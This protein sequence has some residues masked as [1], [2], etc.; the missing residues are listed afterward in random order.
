M[1]CVKLCARC[2]VAKPHADFYKDKTVSDG[3]RRY[4][5][6][7]WQGIQNAWRAANPE[8]VK[9]SAARHDRKRRVTDPLHFVKKIVNERRRQALLRGIPFEISLDTVPPVP[10]LC[11]ALGIPLISGGQDPGLAPSLDRLV[12]SLGYVVGNVAWISKRANQIKSDATLEELEL[13]TRWT[14]EQLSPP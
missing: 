2:G 3:L 11:P 4:C 10:A 8:K 13:V 5:K 7:C 6:P 12:P 1:D 14:R 9:A